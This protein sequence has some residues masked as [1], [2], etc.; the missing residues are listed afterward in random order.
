MNI[1]AIDAATA[2]LSLT[3]QKG[4]SYYQYN[5]DMGFRHSELIMPAVDRLFKE[6]DLK[7]AELDLVVTA[8]G[9][10][11][12]TGLRVGMAT[13]KGICAGT[14]TPFVAVPTLDVLARPFLLFD[15]IVLPIIDARK[16]RVFS[17]LYRKGE[18]L[19][20]YDD[21]APA[22]LMD[23][24]DQTAEE[25]EKVIL[26]GPDCSLLREIVENRN[27]RDRFLFDEECRRGNGLSLIVLGRKLFEERGGDSMDTGPLYMRKSEAE[28]SLEE[29]QKKAVEKD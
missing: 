27:D 16:K 13:A 17:A 10:G 24:V 5:G 19:S 6:A 29:K 12:F 1:L 20:E 26:T 28:I 9:P 14:E 18:R 7:P 22:D 2:I 8:L 25:S 11:S 3:L 4:E 21:I 15:G 23:L